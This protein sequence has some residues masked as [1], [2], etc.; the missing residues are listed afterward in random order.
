MIDAQNSSIIDIT[1]GWLTVNSNCNSRCT[2]CYLGESVKAPARHMSIRMAK[3]AID[4]YVELGIISLIFIGGEPTLYPYLANLAGYARQKGVPEI[5]VVTNGR[6]MSDTKYTTTLA[7]AGID[8]FS[9]TIH[10]TRS[11]LHDL[12][13]GCSAAHQAFAG[14]RNVVQTGKRCSINLVVS[15]DNFDD[16]PH[17]IPVFLNEW[18][19]TNVTVS[20]ANPAVT[21][22][23]VDGSESLH[24]HRF[25]ELIVKLADFSKEVEILHELPICIIP[26][27]TLV[28]LLKEGRLGFGC[29]IGLG[30]GIILDVD[31][32]ILPCNSFSGHKM[33]KLFDGPQAL[34]TA[35]DFLRIWS[36]SPPFKELRA[37]AN[38]Y[39]SEKC[40]Q[41]GIWA[42]CNGGCPIVF[43]HYEPDEIILGSSKSMTLERIQRLSRGG[44]DNE[45]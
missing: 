39:R 42:I 13:S 31:G 22:E 12:I 20:C 5:T 2:W 8:T 7:A 6:R 18:G 21:G 19:V 30:N 1:T 45:H 40:K 17:S 34:Y 44:D 38:V 28:K 14:I 33:L 27:G 4:F 15:K 24:P 36:S 25:A 43:G 9:M 37:N 41:C 3:N 32:D 10:S 23:T 29:H 16:V 11:D 35:N 26:E